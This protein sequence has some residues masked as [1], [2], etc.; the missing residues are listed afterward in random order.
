MR[1]GTITN[2]LKSQRGGAVKS[3]IGFLAGLLLLAIIVVGAG[4]YLAYQEAKK[5]G[6]STGPAIVMLEP[7]SSVSKIAHELED[8]GVIR[9]ADFF[10]AVVRV[11]Q[12]ENDLKAGEYEIPAQASVF[13]NHRYP[14]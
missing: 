14:D 9:Y 5:P 13:R 12:V 10:T 7:G 6:P 1:A 2:K 11:K 8:A 3:I 4:G